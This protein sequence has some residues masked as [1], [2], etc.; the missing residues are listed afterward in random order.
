VTFVAIPTGTA[1][2]APGL[3]DGSNGS[4]WR[5]WGS[6]LGLPLVERSLAAK[7]SQPSTPTPTPVKPSGELAAYDH[8]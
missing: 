3:D 4:G 2:R 7:E 1:I 8:R 6:A 5:G